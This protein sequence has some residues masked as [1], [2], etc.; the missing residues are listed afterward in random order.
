MAH[1]EGLKGTPE[2]VIPVHGG[3]L[4]GSNIDRLIA[5]LPLDCASY[6]HRRQVL[7]LGMTSFVADHI[8]VESR[9]AVTITDV[10]MIVTN[11]LL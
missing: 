3:T 11:R 7:G 6:A 4:A 9:R 5:A 1:A 8:F 2:D 10:R